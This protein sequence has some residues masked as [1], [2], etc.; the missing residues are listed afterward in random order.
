[1][2]VFLFFGIFF[3]VLVVLFFS[4]YKEDVGETFRLVLS[5]LGLDFCFGI[6]F[7]RIVF[8]LF[9][10]CLCNYFTLYHL[11]L[12]N[13]FLKTNL[14]ILYFKFITTHFHF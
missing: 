6:V 5:S 13:I 8:S 4:D 2:R 9:V 7:F 10:F 1:M 3:V 12:I 11:V 14:L